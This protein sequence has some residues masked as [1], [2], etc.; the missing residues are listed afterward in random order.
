ML[1]FLFLNLIVNLFF[2]IPVAI[3]QISNPLAQL[4]IPF[5]VRTKEGNAEI[6]IH[7]VIV[8]AKM[9]KSSIKFKELYKPFCVFH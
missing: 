7:P 5:G 2:L 1:L 6:E 4:L 3:A 8:E 9:R